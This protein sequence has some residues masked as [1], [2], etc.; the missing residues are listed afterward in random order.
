[1]RD[2]TTAVNA[3]NPRRTRITGPDGRTVRL[4]DLPLVVFELKCGHQG[5]NYAI[6][7]GDWLFCEDCGAEKRVS[8]IIA[9]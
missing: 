6:E 4:S 1:M 5:K 3:A 9:K 7:L 2:K 8:R